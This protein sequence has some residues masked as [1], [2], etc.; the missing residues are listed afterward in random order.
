MSVRTSVR[1]SVRN[2]FLVRAIS[3][4]ILNVEFSNFFPNNILIEVVQQ[5]IQIQIFL[6]MFEVLAKKPLLKFVFSP[7]HISVTL[8][9]RIAGLFCSV[10]K[11][12]P[13]VQ[14]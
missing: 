13:I 7:V 2:A 4:R 3:P 1:P 10:S 11:D 6:N 14:R 9:C 12:I 8:N 5:K